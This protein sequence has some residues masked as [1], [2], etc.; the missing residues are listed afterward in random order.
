MTLGNYYIALAVGDIAA[1]KEFYEKL[2]F[3]ADP[4]CGGIEQR[5]LMMSNGSCMI[6][7]YQ[8]MFPKN[9]ITFNPADA[10][11]IHSDLEQGGVTVQMAA[12]IEKE[13]GPCHFMVIDPD[14]NPVL[15]D[16]HF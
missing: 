16:Q 14:G 1:S 13:S 15:V 2:G 7:L 12:N 4:N 3:A 9:T 6:G 10:R 8:G 5:W 11:S